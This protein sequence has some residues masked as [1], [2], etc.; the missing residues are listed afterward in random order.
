MRAISQQEAEKMRNAL[1]D[2][3]SF[4]N[5][6]KD[7]EDPGQRAAS[8]ARSV[9]EEVGLYFQKD[10]HDTSPGNQRGNV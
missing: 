5:E 4:G 8:R 2:I 1:R 6:G 9:L 3:A 7:P 10:A